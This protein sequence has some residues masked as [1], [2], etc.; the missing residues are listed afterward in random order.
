MSEQSWILLIEDNEAN[1]M[2]ASAVLE[3]DGLDVRWAGS[4]QAARRLLLPDRPALILMD[5]QLPDLDGMSFTRQLKADPATS[6]IPVVALTAHAMDG[7]RE[8]ALEAGCVG[9]ITKPIDVKVFGAVVRGYMS[10]P[11]S[12]KPVSLGERQALKNQ[13]T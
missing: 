1:R 6:S 4:A 11:E 12:L 9:Y 13:A 5:M 7:Y 2:L 10:K 3:L 8:I